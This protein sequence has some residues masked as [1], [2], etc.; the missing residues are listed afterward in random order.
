M[1]S[2]T[3]EQGRASSATPSKLVGLPP[4]RSATPKSASGQTPPGKLDDDTIEDVIQRATASAGAGPPPGKDTRTQLFVGNLPYRVRWQDLKDLFRKAGTVLRADVSLGPDNRSRGY[5]TVLLATAEDAGKA[6]DMYN[7]YVWQN[8]TL[9][10]RPDRLPPELD[11]GLNHGGP[12]TAAPSVPITN[13]M[14][15]LAVPQPGHALDPLSRPMSAALGPDVPAHSPGF[16]TPSPYGPS[17]SNW[18]SAGYQA[19]AS[20]RQLFIGNLPFQCQWQDLKDLFRSAGQ[21]LRADVALGPDGRSRGFGT[22]VYA[23]ESDAARAVTMFNGYDYN[24][25]ILKVHYDRYSP[26]NQSGSLS[27]NSLHAVAT[28]PLGI[29]VPPSQADGNHQVGGMHLAMPQTPEYMVFPPHSQPASPF[30][31]YPPTAQMHALMNVYDRAA[32]SPPPGGRNIIDTTGL[33]PSVPGSPGYGPGSP[34]MP[35]SSIHPHPGPITLPP[36]GVAQFPPASALS[37]LLTRAGGLPPMTPSMPGFNFNP[38]A[39][40]TPPLH[41][42]FLSPGLGPFSPQLHSPPFVPSAPNPYLNPAPGAPPRLPN[43]PSSLFSDGPGAFGMHHAPM[44][45]GYFPPHETG[46]FGGVPPGEGNTEKEQGSDSV[47]QSETSQLGL[48]D[49]PTGSTTS[50]DVGE[51]LALQLREV[52]LDETIA[53]DT[54]QRPSLGLSRSSLPEV[55]KIDPSGSTDSALAIT[56]DEE[57]SSALGLGLGASRAPGVLPIRTNLND[58]GFGPVGSGDRRASWN[59]ATSRVRAGIQAPVP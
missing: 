19:A 30:E 10:V 35:Q 7:G 12:T 6:T 4:G 57:T 16:F 59:A 23:K 25:R 36:A 5:G 46:Y 11:M 58:E 41:P 13:P 47:P 38:Q 26:T 2:P 21:I 8:R 20:N 55:S 17:P 1:A 52:K 45:S 24:G 18:S 9:E 32:L 40:A 37:P 34:Q 44:H 29:M 56:P 22:V 49:A 28:G 31:Q 3:V 43:A 39:V 42:H 50:F 48:G 15:P 54:P 51:G 53:G 33:P 14:V 27:P